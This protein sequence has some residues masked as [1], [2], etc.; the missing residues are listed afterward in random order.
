MNQEGGLVI[1][2]PF[3]TYSSPIWTC[4]N[5]DT[6]VAVG[7]FHLF[8]DISGEAELRLQSSTNHLRCT[9]GQHR[10]PEVRPVRT[11]PPD[12]VCD[13]ASMGAAGTSQNRVML[14]TSNQHVFFNPLQEVQAHLPQR[15]DSWFQKVVQQ[16]TSHDNKT[17]NT[18]LYTLNSPLFCG[19]KEQIFVVDL[20]KFVSWVDENMMDAGNGSINVNMKWSGLVWHVEFCACFVC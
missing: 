7:A 13:V 11:K 10:V 6:T 2:G 18:V 4:S 14:H 19:V 1:S 9:L 12:M 15:D 8:F 3:W 20:N 16:H 17:Q 5:V